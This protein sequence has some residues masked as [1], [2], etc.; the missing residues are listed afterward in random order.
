MNIIKL[1]FY[2]SN[3]VRLFFMDRPLPV[4]F[5]RIEHLIKS[6]FVMF[7]IHGISSIVIPSGILFI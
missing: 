6:N 5:L 3:F 4:D 7:M 1:H 2:G